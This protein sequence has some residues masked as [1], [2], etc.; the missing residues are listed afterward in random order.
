MV[1]RVLKPLVERQ[2]WHLWVQAKLLLFVLGV[3][4][5]SFMF[6]AAFWF[7]K[8]LPVR[9]PQRA[10]L[11]FCFLLALVLVYMLQRQAA[12]RRLKRQLFEARLAAI[13]MASWVKARSTPP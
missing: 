10:F 3:S 4:L 6:P 13:W 1:A 12:V 7:E 5:L 11:G 9:G 8:E 2:D